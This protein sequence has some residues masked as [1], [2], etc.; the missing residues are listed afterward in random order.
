[1]NDGK[2]Q[3][4]PLFVS[5]IEY[6]ATTALGPGVAKNWEPGE[7][8]IFLSKNAISDNLLARAGLNKIVYCVNTAVGIF[9]GFF[10]PAIR[11][12]FAKYDK[13]WEM[14]SESFPT[15]WRVTDIFIFQ[16]FVIDLDLCLTNLSLFLLSS[17]VL[18]FSCYIA[19]HTNC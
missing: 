13:I 18:F 17:C 9:D 12:H 14:C 16:V 1:M 4:R 5:Y 15:M 11:K 19:L 8:N 2:P 10:Y 7:E 3:G 6:N